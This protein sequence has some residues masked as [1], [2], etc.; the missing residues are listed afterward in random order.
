[1]GLTVRFEE[2]DA[3]EDARL[4]FVVILAVSAGKLIFCRHRERDSWELPGGHRETGE[5]ALEAARRELREETGAVD[6]SL[7]A[8]CAYSVTGANRA[9]PAGGTAYGLLCLAEVRSLREELRHEI[10][11]RR[12]STRIPG[13]WTYPEIQPK[14]L[15]EAARRGFAL[16]GRETDGP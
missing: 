3:V 7:R 11:E 10:A 4:R 5:T 12:L 8:V 1:M 15:A 6:F 16:P 9:N 2:A 13:R 14:L